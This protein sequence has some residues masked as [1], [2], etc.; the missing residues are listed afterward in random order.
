MSF[1]ES[2]LQ[3]LQSLIEEFSGSPVVSHQECST[4]D[5]L[6]V[7][8]ALL[9]RRHEEL[10]VLFATGSELGNSEIVRFQIEGDS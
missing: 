3:S 2:V 8:D 6:E 7:H 9:E 10:V 4:F 5:L 1:A